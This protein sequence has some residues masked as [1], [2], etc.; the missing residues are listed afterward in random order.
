VDEENPIDLVMQRMAALGL[1]EKYRDNIE[2]LSFA[3][4]DLI[5]E[6]E[7]LIEQA[8]DLDPVLTILDSLSKVALGADENSNTEM[9]KVFHSGITPLARDVGS[10]VV[11]I[12]HT[13]SDGRQKPRGAGAIKASADQ[14]LAMVAAEHKDGSKTGNINLF[15]NKQRRL[16]QHLT[17]SIQGELEDG[18]VRVVGEGEDTPF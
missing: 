12:H 7:L 16:L 10:A 5:N 11:A 3:G 8:L 9:T 1:E 13:P 4:V 18:F 2:Y 14:V 6:P 17:F 15:P